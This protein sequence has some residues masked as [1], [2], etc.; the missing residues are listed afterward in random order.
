[1]AS[2]EEFL[3]NKIFMNA[4]LPLL[5]VIVADTPSL[6]K[7]FNAVH[8]VYQVSALD[9]E[10]PGG[11]YALS[12]DLVWLPFSDRPADRDR[13]SEGDCGDSLAVP[14]V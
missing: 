9:P 3:T 4:V 14:P 12:G 7:K 11:K 8:C 1:M 6:A 5:K 2:R 10:A 13:Q